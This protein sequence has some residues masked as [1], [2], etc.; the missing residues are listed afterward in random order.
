LFTSVGRDGIRAAV[1]ERTGTTEALSCWTGA[2]NVKRQ[3]MS[4]PKF[5]A[6]EW[7]L[8]GYDASV[9]VGSDATLQRHGRHL[10]SSRAGQS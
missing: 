10:P 3:R 2:A 5:L 1:L 7:T 9:S 6:A 4:I 8:D